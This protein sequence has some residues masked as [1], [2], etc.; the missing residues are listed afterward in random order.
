M[1]IKDNNELPVDYYKHLFEC[2]SIAII[3]ADANG[4]ITGV[5][6]QAKILFKEILPKMVGNN[7]AEILP[8][9]YHQWGIE[10]VESARSMGKVS[11][12]EFEHVHDDINLTM[13][14]RISA[15]QDEKGCVH[16]VSG[17]VLDITHRTQLKKQLQ[18]AE[19]ITSLG[20]LAAGVAH[21]FNNIMGG[22][23][24]FVDFAKSSHNPLAMGQA[25]DM[26][27]K[28]ANRVSKITGSLLT[29]AEKDI[30]QFDLE[31]LT[32]V[33]LA[34][35][36]TAEIELPDKRIE[37]V[38]DI[39]SVPLFEVPGS[40]IYEVLKNL[41]TNAEKA[42]P[43]GGKIKIGLRQND[44]RIVLSFS[45]NGV[46]ISPENIPQIF[47]PFFTTEGVEW[48][49]DCCDSSGLGLAVVQGIVR[50]LGGEIQVKSVVGKGTTFRMSFPLVN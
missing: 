34:F 50:E 46:G 1:S 11:E 42:M 24:T 10:A 39:N 8:E 33:V 4:R 45:D 47:D 15:V 27:A 23:S 6:N 7:L 32:E 3:S 49:G 41:R 30:R 13:L 44:D 36:H 19:K 28:A 29:F 17:W 38:A 5:N 22:V 21:H 18:E 26:T 40:K 2:S 25:L 9:R 43:K 16:G 12:L 35:I 48:G 20:I 31:D 37:L 14:M